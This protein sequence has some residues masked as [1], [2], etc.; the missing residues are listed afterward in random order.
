MNYKKIQQYLE[1]N[2]IHLHS[3][4]D[5]E[6]IINFFSLELEKL[7]KKY[8]KLDNELIFKVIKKIIDIFSVKNVHLVVPFVLFLF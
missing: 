3:T 6:L 5:S 1:E 2:Y 7:I 4:S 8:K